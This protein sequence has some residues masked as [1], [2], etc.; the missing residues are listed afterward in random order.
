MLRITT[1]DEKRFIRETGLTAPTLS[2]EPVWLTGSFDPARPV[3]PQIEVVEITGNDRFGNA[4]IQMCAARAVARRCGA[5]R[6]FHNRL[7]W[8]PDDVVLEGIRYI[9]GEIPLG[10]ERAL[11]APFLHRRTLAPLH[12]PADFVEGMR[13]L[14]SAIAFNTTVT[15]SD[16][17][18]LFIHLR[19]GDL[20]EGGGAH[21]LYGQPP[22][23]FYRKVLASRR[24]SHVTLV[25][26]TDT[27]PVLPGLVELLTRRAVPFAVQSSSLFED[28]GTLLRARNLVAARGTFALPVI[29]LSQHLRRV[30][31][32]EAAGGFVAHGI[33][34][35]GPEI[36][37]YRDV[38]GL[39]RGVLI[40][41]ENTEAQHDLMRSLPDTAI[42]AS[43]T[44]SVGWGIN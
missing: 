21:P 22:L 6:I 27:N 28:I 18:A 24:W 9:G 43:N 20:F 37:N 35:A 7:D 38:S 3:L 8:F 26:E 13:A 39:Y 32:F 40:G 11:H 29:A 16:D 34:G 5:T 23:A 41:W 31:S 2:G 19:A 17:D 42:A 33:D 10:H 30:Y 44:D 15:P 4:S 1:D 14:R 12:G 25:F 36:F